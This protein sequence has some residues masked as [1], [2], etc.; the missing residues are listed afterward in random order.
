MQAADIQRLIQEALPSAEVLV[1]GDDGVHFEAV[2]VSSVFEGQRTLKR[3]Q[4]VYATLGDAMGGEIHA[5]SLETL[6]PGEASA[7]GA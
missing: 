5:L 7:R 6:T 2:V 1:R 3:H 4:L